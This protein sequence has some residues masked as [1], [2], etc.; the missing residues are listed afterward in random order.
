MDCGHFFP[1]AH[2]ATRWHGDNCHSQCITCNR[3][4]YGNIEEYRKHLKEKI[5]DEAYEGIER[6]HYTMEDE[7][8]DAEY[9]QLIEGY[10]ECCRR[11]ARAKGIK[12]GI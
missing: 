8:S 11:L 9:R 7:P 1:R 5:G 12:I 2:L 3:M 4:E 6:L 10:R